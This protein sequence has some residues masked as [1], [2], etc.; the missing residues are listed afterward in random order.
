MNEEE[1]LFFAGRDESLCLY[2]VFRQRLMHDVPDARVKV[3]KT[4]ISFFLSRMF[5]CVSFLPVKR[6][7]ERGDV[8][9][10]VTF[11]LPYMN[12]NE[13]CVCSNPS[14]GRFTH[15]VLV[16]NLCDID[17][18]LMVWINEAADAAS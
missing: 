2:E 4:Q 5:A 3:S 16:R 13:R 18:E 7:A 9:I 14:P 10:T 1:K 8:F 12:G 6:K 11:S 15:H 17:D